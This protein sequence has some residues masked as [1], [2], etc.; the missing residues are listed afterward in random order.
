[1][2]EQTSEP[3]DDDNFIYPELLLPDP[4]AFTPL[5]IE[6][7][8]LMFIHSAFEREVGALQDVITTKHGFGEHRKNQY[9]TRE[10]P[11]AMVKLIKKYRGKDF[12]EIDRIEQLLTDAIDLCED[13]H[14]LAHGDW[15]RFNP[16]TSTVH[17]RGGTRRTALK[18]RLSS[19]NTTC[20]KFT[21]PERS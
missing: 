9:K 7:V 19:A 15:W 13:R 5:A 1:M 2:N 6:F 21:G 10:R 11:T 14:H 17:V 16:K 12:P 3:L 18:R 8:R 4:D 20:L